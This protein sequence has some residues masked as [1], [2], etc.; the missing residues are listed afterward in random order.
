MKTVAYDYRVDRQQMAFIKFTIEAYEGVAIMSTL[1]SAAGIVRLSVAPGC[2][3]VVEALVGDLRRQIRM[4]PLPMDRL[5]LAARGASRP[6][7]EKDR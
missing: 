5:V 2:E 1:D 4:E 3:A 6:V 7:C